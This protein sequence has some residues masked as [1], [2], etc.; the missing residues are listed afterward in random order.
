MSYYNL[1]IKLFVI[2]NGGYASMR[3][4]QDTFFE[5]RRI[6]SDDYTG[7]Q[8][9]NLKKVADAFELPYEIIERWEDADSKIKSVMSNKKPFFVEVICDDKQKLIEP[10]KSV[11]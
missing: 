9:L 8:T 11:L 6:G 10:I 7:A 5:G 2:N 1:N 4:W 3:R